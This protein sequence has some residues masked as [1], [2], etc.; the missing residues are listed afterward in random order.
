EF[1][2]PLDGKGEAVDVHDPH[3]C[4]PL[5][6]TKPLEAIHARPPGAYKEPPFARPFGC[7][8]LFGYLPSWT[9]KRAA[10][11]SL[12]GP[13]ISSP[14]CGGCQVTKQTMPR[15]RRPRLPQGHTRGVRLGRA[16]IVFEAWA[17]PC[18]LVQ[19]K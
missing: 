4:F 19:A 5:R 10:S 12:A 1:L 14:A 11:S 2:N 13:A 9:P 7:S 16:S 3:K 18:L 17:A 8:T 15:P 6:P